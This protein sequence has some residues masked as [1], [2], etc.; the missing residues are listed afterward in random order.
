VLA[1]AET[2][3]VVV[4]QF[5]RS[6]NLVDPPSHL[7]RPSTML[8]VLNKSRK[9]TVVQKATPSAEKRDAISADSLCDTS[10]K[11][12]LPGT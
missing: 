8:R 7:L 10:L 5:L 4:Q 12:E 9:R 1:A 3:P 6:M 11:E 2:D